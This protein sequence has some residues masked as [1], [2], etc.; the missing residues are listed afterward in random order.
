MGYTNGRYVRIHY[1][2]QLCVDDAFQYGAARDQQFRAR[3]IQYG[4][5]ELQREVYWVI[6][7]SIWSKVA[8][9]LGRWA[10]YVL[11]VQAEFEP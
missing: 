2:A 8:R 10:A 7:C 3:P 11:A 4:S 9:V 5:G 6:L 1:G